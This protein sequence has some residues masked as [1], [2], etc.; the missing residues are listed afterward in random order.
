MERVQKVLA[1]AG[2][3]SRRKCEEFIL[4]GR[5]KINKKVINKL[6][7]KVDPKKDI[8]EFDNKSIKMKEEKIYIILNKPVNYVTTMSDPRGRRT[9]ADLVKKIP[10]RIYPV[11]RLDYDTEG[12]LLMTNDGELTYKLT[13]PSHEVQ[14][15]YLAV[16]KGFPDGQA[17]NKLKSGILL[18][19]GLTSPAE[20]KVLKKYKNSSML[21]ITIHEGR[22]RQVRR[23]CEAVGYPVLKLKRIQVAFLKL[24]N[25]KVGSY[26]NL[27]ISEIEKLKQVL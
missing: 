25:L 14:K 21:Q 20:A 22:N 13:H 10:Q 5:V 18:E 23:M 1:R 3:A 9:A 11:G 7:T 24:G 2:V 12:L 6:G 19:D 27:T 15:T 17:L 4:Q 8:I 26:R 16:V